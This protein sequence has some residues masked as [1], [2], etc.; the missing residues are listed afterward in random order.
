MRP[1]PESVASSADPRG[2]TIQDPKSTKLSEFFFDKVLG[3]ADGGAATTQVECFNEVALPLVAGLYS[4][5]IRC[6]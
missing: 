1:T 3:G 2:L 5:C 6:P 4:C